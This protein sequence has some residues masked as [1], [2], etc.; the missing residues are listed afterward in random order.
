MTAS[1]A[2][3]WRASATGPL[4]CPACPSRATTMS[5]ARRLSRVFAAPDLWNAHFALPANGPADLPELAGQNYYL[6]YQGVRIVALDV[7]AFANEDFRESQRSRVQ[8]AQLTWLR[9]VLGTNPQRW[10]IVVQHYPMYSVAKH[11]DFGRMRAALGAL[12]D[13]FGVDLVLQG[14]DHAYGRTHKVYDGRLVDPQSPGTVYAVSVSGTKMYSVSS[15]WASL[16]ARLHGGAQL[17]QVVS[18]AG[19]RL[20]YESREADGTAVDAFELIKTAAQHRDTSTGRPV[21]SRLVR[22][23]D[24]DDLEGVLVLG[25]RAEADAAVVEHHA[26]LGRDERLDPGIR[27]RF[28]HARVE[29][30]AV[31]RLELGLV[32]DDR[33][34]AIHPRRQREMDELATLRRLPSDTA[35]CRDFRKAVTWAVSVPAASKAGVACARTLPA[36]GGRHGI[37]SA[38]RTIGISASRIRYP[39]LNGAYTP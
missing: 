23:V 38:S 11:R 12:Y 3:G 20:S 25:Q 8:A 28:L 24:R 21:L 26:L 16:M 17:Y 30:P 9:H 18:V 37:R 36:A 33:F 32:A 27:D 1:G 39:A 29:H 22:V 5:C 15:R 13:E 10:T 14:H 4:S 19:D 31:A 6:D 35:D 34:L 2:H 7:N